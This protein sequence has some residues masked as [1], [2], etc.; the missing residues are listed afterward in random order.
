MQHIYYCYEQQHQH[1]N[2]QNLQNN[3]QNHVKRL[4]VVPQGSCS[5]LANFY[6]NN[7]LQNSRQNHKCHNRMSMASWSRCNGDGEHKRIDQSRIWLGQGDLAA[8][9]NRSNCSPSEST[10]IILTQRFARTTSAIMHKLQ[11]NQVGFYQNQPSRFQE[12]AQ[13]VFLGFASFNAAQPASNPSQ[14]M[15]S[16]MKS[17]QER[18]FFICTPTWMYHICFFDH[19]VKRNAMVKSILHFDNFGKSGLASFAIWPSLYCQKTRARFS[20]T[21]LAVN[22]C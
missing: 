6:N 17:S 15:F 2:A 1:E 7:T 5:R 21:I 4:H 16:R 12:S 11:T 8:K 10:K 19:P 3:N 9:Q 22:R 18:N 13:T 14:P 20:C